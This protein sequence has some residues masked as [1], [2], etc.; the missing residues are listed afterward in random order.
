[1]QAQEDLTVGG[2]WAQQWHSSLID[3]LQFPLNPNQ[4]AVNNAQHRHQVL[5]TKS[6]DAVEKGLLGGLLH[7]SSPCQ[8]HRLLWMYALALLWA[9]CDAGPAQPPSPHCDKRPVRKSDAK[10][11]VLALHCR[12]QMV[13]TN[14]PISFPPLPLPSSPYSYAYSY[15]W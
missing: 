6:E 2:Q 5:L 7:T 12:F 11:S 15:F 13:L 3:P 4:S 14:L 10:A 8:F 9:H 1:M